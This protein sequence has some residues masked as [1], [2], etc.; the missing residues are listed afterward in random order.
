MESPFDTGILLYGLLFGLAA[1]ALAYCFYF[2]GLA[3]IS[4]PSK[5][6]VAASVELVVATFFG[7]AAFRED[8]TAVK[9]AGIILVI[10]SIILFSRRTM[11]EKTEGKQ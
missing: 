10:F 9:I 2:S 5:V 7:A 4:H 8:M 3:K 6:T 11:S 1:T